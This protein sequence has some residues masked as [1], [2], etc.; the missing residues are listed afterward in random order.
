MKR[1]YSIPALVLL[2]V[3]ALIGWWYTNQMQDDTPEQESVIDPSVD[4]ETLGSLEVG[5]S[6]QQD[7]YTVERLPDAPS[8]MT[9]TL[10]RAIPP[11]GGTVAGDA[12]AQAVANMN[13]LATQL[14]TNSSNYSA[15]LSLGVY[16][17]LLGDYIGAE[18][19]WV[20]LTRQYGGAWEAYANLGNLYA[21]NIRNGEKS[22]HAFTQ[23][24]AIKKD[25]PQLY[26]S[27]FEL[28]IS[29]K[30]DVD[31]INILTKG[32]QQAPNAI[33]LMVL[34]ARHYTTLGNSEQAK[35]QYDAAIVVAQS[36]NNTSL[37]TSL[38]EER[39]KL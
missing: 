13:A 24:I 23:A 2:V 6:V 9:P 38:Q 31:A 25:N 8:T 35:A 36:Q 7:G 39:A 15:W 3:A 16:R 20:Y 1:K 30:R 12:R 10:T 19:V 33:D 4:N 18:E 32:I 27:L 37:V 34:L 11:T 26:R 22:A 21:T 29:E 17:E 14:Q 28:Y 5:G